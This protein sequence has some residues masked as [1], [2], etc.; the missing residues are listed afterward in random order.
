K[1][2]SVTDN[3]RRTIRRRAREYSRKSTDLIPWFYEQYGYYLNQSQISRILS[4]KYDY[5]D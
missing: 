5:L 3:E 1:R 4:P 2:V